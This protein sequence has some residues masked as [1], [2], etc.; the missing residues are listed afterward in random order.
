MFDKIATA[1]P[2]LQYIDC[3]RGYAVLLVM[4][5]HLTYEIVELPDHV[6]RFGKL[7]WYGVQ[8]FF[9][10]SAYTL[11]SSWQAEK[12]KY[13]QVSTRNFFIRRFLRIA[14][15][16]Y[17]AVI[18]YF[19]LAPPAHFDL[20]RLLTTLSFSNSWHPQT[21]P[22]LPGW[23][24]VPGEWSIGV[25]FSFYMIF[26]LLA[27][28]ITTLYRA[29]V[30]LFAAVCIA[31]IC[32]FAAVYIYAGTPAVALSNFRY[33]WLPNEL[34]VFV[35]GILLYYLMGSGSELSVRVLSSIRPFR[36]TLCGVA[37]AMFGCIIYVPKSHFFGESLAPPEVLYVSVPFML[38][39]ASL[40]S[41][42]T[43]LVNRAVQ[44]V[45]KVSFSA[46][47]LHF[48]WLDLMRAHPVLFGFSSEGY[49][50]IGYFLFDW[51]FLALATFMV[52]FVQY[53]LIEL[54]AMRF[55][56]TITQRAH[57]NQF[58]KANRV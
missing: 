5:V 39:A 21:M 48:A 58:A 17:G 42:A 50:A 56:K 28:A 25:E 2:H 7:G 44:A 19:L 9:L 49:L 20:T 31:L 6:A 57:P 33:F 12:S 34:S 32:N 29:L 16:Y 13:G 43:L 26:P 15:A 14:P 47:L 54:P 8:L 11:F 22:D 27:Y 41:G 45:G 18:L 46:Y 52:A 38:F 1:K 53:N 23:L 36:Y 35:L 3:L 37:L 24:V 51:S 4:T 40:A 10:M 55:A 30:A